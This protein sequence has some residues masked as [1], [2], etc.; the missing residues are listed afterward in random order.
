MSSKLL[1][2]EINPLSSIIFELIFQPFDEFIESFN[3]NDTRDRLV[4]FS[5]IVDENLTF[6]TKFRPM[7]YIFLRICMKIYLIK[8]YV[9]NNLFLLNIVGPKY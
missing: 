1:E 3:Q 8:N 6:I 7:G 5:F 2:S 9:K 4:A